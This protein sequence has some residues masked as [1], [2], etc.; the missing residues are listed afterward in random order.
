MALLQARP[1]RRANGSFRNH[2]NANL[3]QPLGSYALAGATVVEA[4]PPCYSAHATATRPSSPSVNFLVTQRTF[5]D[6]G[7]SHHSALES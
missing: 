7:N 4:Q 1:R 6:G 3:H 5:I 2:W